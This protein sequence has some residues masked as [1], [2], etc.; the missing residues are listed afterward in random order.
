MHRTMRTSAPA[1]LALFVAVTS[2]AAPAADTSTAPGASTSPGTTVSA[3]PTATPAPA[4][5]GHPAAGLALLQWPDANSPVSHVF[6]VDEDGSLRQVTGVSR[7][8]TGASLPA[9]SP[10]RSRIAFGPVKT[11]GGMTFE[12][13]VVNADGT[14]ERVVGIGQNPQWSP[15]GTRVL[16]EEVDDVTAEPRSMYVVDVETGELTDL[17]Q[18][19]SPQW[20]PDGE[21]I[22]FLR[23][24][25]SPSDGGPVV[26]DYVID[27]VSVSGGEHEELVA[28]EA[29]AWAPDGSGCLLLREGTLSFA[30]PDGS[31]PRVVVDG[32]DP[33]WAPD[34]QSFVF[35]HGV[36]Q[37]GIPLLAVS[38]LEGHA[39][40]SGIPGAAPTWSP[41]GTRIA[42]EM[43]VPETSV[44]VLDASTGGVLW[45]TPG[46]QPEWGVP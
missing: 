16:F 5:E 38:D 7:Q 9:W 37:N 22:S 17:G 27:T 12:V 36:N 10:D 33:L 42:V 18:G 25:E 46:A 2:C 45:E 3:D 21:Q 11:G 1:I 4:F 44:Q 28:A 6:A 23:P 43:P 31:N 24:F 29:I 8:S 32:G 40:W 19:A 39:L 30:E 14:D 34:G 15:D 26:M 20:M 35:V 41:D 13:G